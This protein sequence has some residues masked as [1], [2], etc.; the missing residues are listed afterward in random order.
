[1][2]AGIGKLPDTVAD[3]SIPIQ[4]KRKGPAEN[5][6]RFR[7]RL[8]V[9]AAKDLKDRL[10]AWGALAQNV[11]LEEEFPDLPG[12]L[13]DRQQDV[14]EPLLAIADFAVGEWSKTAREALLEIFGSTAAEDESRVFCHADAG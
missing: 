2:I 10:I 5:T 6:E 8:V 3:R 4:L 1:M 13:S 9:H 14:C 7:H 11:G 12:A